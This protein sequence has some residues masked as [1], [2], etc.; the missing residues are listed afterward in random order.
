MEDGFALARHV[1]ACADAPE[2]ALAAYQRER[3]PRASKV[4]LQARQQ[5]INNQQIPPPPPLPV[6]WIYSHDAVTGASAVPA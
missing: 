2:Q 1:D 4:Q 5:F 3:Q 6:D